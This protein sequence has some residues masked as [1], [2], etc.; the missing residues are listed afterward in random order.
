MG[1]HSLIRPVLIDVAS[2]DTGPALVAAISHDMDLVLA[3]KVPLAGTSSPRARSC[4]MHA[5]AAGA[6]CTRPPSAR[7]SP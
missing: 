7:D 2:G 6:C 1:A 5:P 3:N 4:R